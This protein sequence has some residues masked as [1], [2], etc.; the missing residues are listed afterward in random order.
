M[1]V[2][3]GAAGEG[4]QIEECAD[5]VGRKTGCQGKDVVPSREVDLRGRTGKG[6]PLSK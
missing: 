5:A 3:V 1:V 6:R 4:V 2:G